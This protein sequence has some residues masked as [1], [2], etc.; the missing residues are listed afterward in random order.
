MLGVPLPPAARRIATAD[1]VGGG[2]T[3]AETR[4]V[5]IV[6]GVPPAPTN[7]TVAALSIAVPAGVTVCARAGRTTHSRPASTTPARRAK[8][9]PI[10]TPKAGRL[11]T[12]PPALCITV[13][14]ETLSID[15]SIVTRNLTV[16]VPL[17]VPLFFTTVPALTTTRAGGPARKLLSGKPP[18]FSWMLPGWKVVLAGML[19]VTLTAVASCT[20]LELV[21]TIVYSITAPGIA[22]GLVVRLNGSLINATAFEIVSAT[23]IA[24]W[25]AADSELSRPASAHTTS[26]PAVSAPAVCGIGVVLPTGVAR[27]VRRTLAYVLLAAPAGTSASTNTVTLTPVGPVT[28]ELMLAAASVP[29]SYVPLP[30]L[31]T[32][33][34]RLVTSRLSTW[35]NSVVPVSFATVS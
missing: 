7:V 22:F 10:D 23:L 2:V 16:A 27:A 34:R 12:V 18:P 8:H 15:Q 25:S 28:S 31:S 21:T 30:L 14:E 11:C 20:V 35:V 1:K 26:T 5:V 24:Y 4:L 17:T 33:V 13:C 19:S 6:V 32:N 9:T 29:A 3:M